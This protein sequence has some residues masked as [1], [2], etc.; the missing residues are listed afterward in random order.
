[1]PTNDAGSVPTF[2]TV[3]CTTTNSPTASVSSGASDMTTVDPTSMP[4]TVNDNGPSVTS[5]VGPTVVGPAVG[6][7]VGD[8]VVV[9]EVVSEGS[10]GE[11]VSVVVSVPDEIC[12]PGSFLMTNP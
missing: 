8:S 11:E 10:V 12:T 6:D 1:M 7:S 4:W 2:V 9:S 5:P 3:M